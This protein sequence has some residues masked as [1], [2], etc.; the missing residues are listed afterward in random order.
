MHIDP[1]PAFDISRPEFDPPATRALT[2]YVLV[3]FALLLVPAVHFL[4]SAGAMPAWQSGG[5]ALGLV[6]S[7]VVLGA[8][9]EGRRGSK[10]LEVTR[11]IV[12]AS[13]LA[14]TASSEAMASGAVRRECIPG[15]ARDS[16]VVDLQSRDLRADLRRYLAENAPTSSDAIAAFGAPHIPQPASPTDRR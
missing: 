3:N 1:K 7:L 15:Q 12:I 9:M 10:A 8:L 14:V 6:A 5:Y 13:A 4:V 11:W 16:D 2:A